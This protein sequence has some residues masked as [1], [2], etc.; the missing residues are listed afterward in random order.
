MQPSCTSNPCFNGVV[1]RVSLGEVVSVAAFSLA[2][3]VSCIKAWSVLSGT[4]FTPGFYIAGAIFSLLICSF[5][6]AGVR[7]GAGLDPRA[8]RQP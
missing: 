8:L 6:F 4:P 5:F 7:V 1:M 3:S 2:G